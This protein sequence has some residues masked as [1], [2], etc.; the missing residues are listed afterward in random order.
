MAIAGGALKMSELMMTIGARRAMEAALSLRMIAR[1]FS[2][3]A[4]RHRDGSWNLVSSAS[5][6][7]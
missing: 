3:I 7:S 4:E 1:K 5:A 6:E 2:C